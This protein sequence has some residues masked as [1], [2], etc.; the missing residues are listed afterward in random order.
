MTEASRTPRA[1]AGASGVATGAW[2]LFAKGVAMG[3]AEVVPGVSGGTV[4][5]V[6]GIYDTLV[7][8]LASFSRLSP[9]LLLKDWRTFAREHNLGFFAVLGAGMAIGFAAV[10]QVI[11]WLLEN[12]GGYVFG[13]FFGLIGGAVFYVGAQSRWRWLGSIGVAGLGLGLGV[14]LA[15][16]PGALNTVPSNTLVFAAGALAA[17]AWILPGVSGS[18]VLLM[19]GVYQPLLQALKALELA[20]VG[21]FLA[22][23]GIGLLAFSKLL[24]W[25]LEK[26]RAQVLAL[27]TGVLAGSLTQVWPWRHVGAND[28]P[29]LYGVLA[30]MLLG[31]LVVVALAFAAR[32]GQS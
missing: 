23:V 30:T 11:L 5:F 15:L 9:A 29:L 10:A 6:T 8:S 24:A 16:E 3:V 27:L 20:T 32:R 12:H 7:K 17:T 4:A 22:G 18:F 26:W 1:A 25:L 28:A 21:T 2:P 13:L 31:V 19:L 14:G